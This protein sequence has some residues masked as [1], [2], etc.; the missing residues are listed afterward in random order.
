MENNKLKSI[1]QQNVDVQKLNSKVLQYERQKINL[2]LEEIESEITQLTRT[3]DSRAQSRARHRD[4]NDNKNLRKKRKEALE[5]ETKLENVQTSIGDLDLD[6]IIRESS[7]LEQKY[8]ILKEKKNQAF[9]TKREIE[10]KIKEL[11]ADLAKPQF[12]NAMKDYKEKFID[13]K[14]QEGVIQDL[15]A[16][17]LAMDWALK[18]THT[19][20]MKTI[21]V[22]I[23]ELWRK[24][25]VGNDIDFIEIKTS[26]EETKDA[27]KRRV[28]N[29]RVVQ[30]KN[31]VELDM[32]GR[33]SA[34]QKIL[35]SIIIRLALAE[36]FSTN[37][38]VIT[39]DEPTTNLD[40]DNVISLCNALIN[41]VSSRATQKNFQLII[42]THD[43]D[44]INRLTREEKV[45][46]FWRVYRDNK[47]L[48][49]IM[50]CNPNQ[51]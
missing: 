1:E 28:F 19:E 15:G 7:E 31:G 22:I 42:I 24:I 47:G 39:L 34:G 51:W 26:E 8:E 9:G 35:A 5:L 29:Y 14:V 41:L 32:R 23:R 18:K 16:Y 37:C 49:K 45:R 6:E 27:D 46:C 43:E 12:K 2:Q 11:K 10:T 17:Y 48:S 30:V 25:Y 50:K 38:G 33:C 3:I 4:L 21:N 44:F 13:F 20:R 40:R 36:T